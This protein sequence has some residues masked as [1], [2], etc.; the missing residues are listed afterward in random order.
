MKILTI[1]GKE[2]QYEVAFLEGNRKLI[3]N[4]VK[5]QMES[6]KKFGTNFNALTY[7]KG[8]AANGKKI[9]DV[10]T[11]EEV[12]EE[13]K[14]SYIVVL[15]GQHRYKAALELAKSYQFDLSNLKWTEAVIPEDKTIEDVLIEINTVGQKWKGTDYIT[16]YNL[17]NPDEPVGKFARELANY[18]LSGK[19]INKYLFFCDKFNWGKEDNLVTDKANLERAKDIWEVVSTFPDKVKKQSYI[20]DK[21]ISEG[22]WRETLNRVRDITNEDKLELGKIKNLK[23]LKAATLK[24]LEQN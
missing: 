18:G 7:I 4:N 22:S 10:E 14:S 21:I 11:G 16:G 12:P 23:E 20:I 2:V 5:A 24:L 8:D 13:N 15:D 6:L 17:R 3:P 19:T 9:V 1:N